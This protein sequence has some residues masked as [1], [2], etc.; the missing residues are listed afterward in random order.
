ME[1]NWTLNCNRFPEKYLEDPFSES[2]TPSLFS[3]ALP[4]LSNPAL[5]WSRHSTAT[6]T[7]PSRGQAPTLSQTFITSP[8]CSLLPQKRPYSSQGWSFFPAPSKEET[9]TGFAEN[10]QWLP[11][12]FYPHSTPPQCLPGSGHNLAFPFVSYCFP[13]RAHA[14]EADPLYRPWVC[15]WFFTSQ[16]FLPRNALSAHPSLSAET[17]Q[18][19]IQ[20]HFLI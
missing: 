13:L 18:S 12:T 4:G 9:I 3:Q 1:L 8:P 16:N 17:L 6:S 15:S 7:F 10:L 11:S 14:Q 5:I 20:H 19:P 2:P